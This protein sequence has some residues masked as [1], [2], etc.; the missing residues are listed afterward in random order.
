MDQAFRLL[1]C[2]S[3]NF[4]MSVSYQSDPKAA[5]HVD[6]S[7]PVYVCDVGPDGLLPDDGV[8]VL[9]AQQVCAPLSPGG[10]RRALRIRQNVY[11]LL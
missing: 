11:Q 10:N 7:V 3:N 1:A 8:V 9:L 6:V 2:R 4:R 5:R